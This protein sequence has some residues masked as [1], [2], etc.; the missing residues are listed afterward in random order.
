MLSARTRVVVSV[1]SV[2]ALGAGAELAQAQDAGSWVTVD[3]VQVK[4]EKLSDFEKLYRDEINPA[5][6]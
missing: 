6:R 2:V 4:P 3:I 5:L 1:V